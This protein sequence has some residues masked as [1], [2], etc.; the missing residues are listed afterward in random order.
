MERDASN[1]PRSAAHESQPGEFNAVT[2]GRRGGCDVWLDRDFAGDMG[3]QALWQT[4]IAYSTAAGSS[5]R[6]Q[7]DT[8][9]R[10]SFT[11]T[12][13]VQQ[14]RTRLVY[15]GHVRRRQTAVAH[16]RTRSRLGTPTSSALALRPDRE[17]AE[18][19][20][21][22][23]RT[24]SSCGLWVRLGSDRRTPVVVMGSLR[25]GAILRSPVSDQA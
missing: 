14:I 7:G 3:L 2:D 10:R 1:A 21:T 23:R 19:R 9:A 20:A 4:D 6:T 12:G 22:T 24:A 8:R 16:R 13:I 11:A 18:V 5:I 25:P 17:T 15:R